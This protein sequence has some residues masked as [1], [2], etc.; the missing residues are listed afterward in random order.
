MHHVAVRSKLGG[1]PRQFKHLSKGARRVLSILFLAGLFFFAI[2]SFSIYVKDPDSNNVRAL[3]GK[4]RRR[5]TA[6]TTAVVVPPAAPLRI[7]V[8][9]HNRLFWYFPENKTTAVLHE[10][11][12]G[13]W[14]RAGRRGGGEGGEPEVPRL[15]LCILACRLQP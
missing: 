10:G 9:T 6:A 4:G 11:E 13:Q 14:C 2:L 15:P 12:V 8:A 7:M 3:A 1:A 5:S